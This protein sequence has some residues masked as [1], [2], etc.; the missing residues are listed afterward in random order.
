MVQDPQQAIPKLQIS[1]AF[2]LVFLVLLGSSSKS[3]AT[4]LS[5]GATGGRASLGGYTSVSKI[6]FW[7]VCSYTKKVSYLVYAK[8]VSESMA[9]SWWQRFSNYYR[10]Q[11]MVEMSII[12]CFVGVNIPHTIGK[13]SQA[14]GKWCIF[15][16]YVNYQET[17]KHWILSVNYCLLTKEKVSSYR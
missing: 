11:L 14:T 10:W 6:L 2:T 12:N 17:T 13:F 4:G 1:S 15:F 8:E 16:W 5:V 9:E 3:I 7:L